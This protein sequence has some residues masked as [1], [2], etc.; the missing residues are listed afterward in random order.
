MDEFIN[1][2]FCVIFSR[3]ISWYSVKERIPTIIKVCEVN[4]KTNV[5]IQTKN[6]TSLAITMTDIWRIFLSNCINICNRLFHVRV[7]SFFNVLVFM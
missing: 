5:E 1:K 3:P 6:T 2:Q 4:M 7:P